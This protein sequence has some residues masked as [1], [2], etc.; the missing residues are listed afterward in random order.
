MNF[1]PSSNSNVVVQTVG[2]TKTLH[3]TPCTNESLYI[4]TCC[5]T[6]AQNGFQI[7]NIP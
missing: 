3:L 7:V 5:Q 4:R 6:T 2:Y 1:A